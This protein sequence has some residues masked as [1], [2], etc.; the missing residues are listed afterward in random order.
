MFGLSRRLSH[1]LDRRRAAALAIASSAKA[2]GEAK[3]KA[4]AKA[5]IKS[6]SLVRQQAVLIR[7]RHQY[8]TSVPSFLPWRPF[9]FRSGRP[10]LG[11]RQ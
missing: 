5:T 3:I 9:R 7:R 10:K 2:R 8:R 6:F 4:K 1:S 11:R